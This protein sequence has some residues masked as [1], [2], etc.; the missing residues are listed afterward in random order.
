MDKIMT[1]VDLQ[2]KKLEKGELLQ[3]FIMTHK[4]FVKQVPKRLSGVMIVR[5]Y[6]MSILLVPT[7]M[8]PSMDKYTHAA[9]GEIIYPFHIL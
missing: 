3:V 6:Q 2:N 8:N 9:W 1:R 4:P 7:K 5:Q